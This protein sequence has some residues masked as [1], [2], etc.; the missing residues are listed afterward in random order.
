MNSRARV[1]GFDPTRS[2]LTRVFVF[3][4][5]FWFHQMYSVAVINMSSSCEFIFSKEILNYI[6]HLKLF[7]E[8]ILLQKKKRIYE[9]VSLQQSYMKTRHEAKGN[10]SHF[11]TECSLMSNNSQKKTSEIEQSTQYNRLRRSA[12]YEIFNRFFRRD[13]AC[14]N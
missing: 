12:Q 3:L 2:F 6:Q 10:P 1:Y 13:Q 9:E 7:S 8:S 4:I 11:C 5:S 14:P